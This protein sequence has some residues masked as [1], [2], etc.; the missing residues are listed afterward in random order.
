MSNASAEASASIPASPQV[1]YEILR[2]YQTSH[3]TILPKPWFQ[4]LIVEEG[5]KGAGTVF[6]TSLTIM[7]KSFAYHMD[8]TEPAPLT[9]VEIDRAT[10]LRTTFRVSQDGAGARVTIHTDWKTAAGIAGWIEKL[11]TPSI[12]RKIYRVQLALIEE[13]A[14]TRSAGKEPALAS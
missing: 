4:N 11:G 10:G 7:G 12:M 6:R 5:G 9:L 13:A 2:D 8:V 14:R 1:V 3:P